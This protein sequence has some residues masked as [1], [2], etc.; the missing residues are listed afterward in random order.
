QSN[1]FRPSQ[2]PP[3]NKSFGKKDRRWHAI[4]LK[5]RIGN[6]IVIE[7]AVIKG[8]NNGTRGYLAGR[9]VFRQLAER[10]TIE[11]PFRQIAHVFLEQF[12]TQVMRYRKQG[13]R[14]RQN[15]MIRENDCLVTTE[16]RFKTALQQGQPATSR[17]LYHPD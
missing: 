12:T 5:N 9:D 15:T 7:K 4:A 13:N 11:L 8:D 2:T 17:H 16:K 1:S 10:Y 3:T 14:G 6:T